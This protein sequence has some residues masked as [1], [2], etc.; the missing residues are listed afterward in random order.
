MLRCDADREAKTIKFSNAM[1]FSN[2]NPGEMVILIETLRNPKENVVTSS[3]VVRTESF[4]GYAMDELTTD[5]T[6][7]FYC[8]YP[9]ANCPQGSPSRCESCY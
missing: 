8:E 9:C 3:F 5:L 2:A 6:I 4:D 7:N 1:Q